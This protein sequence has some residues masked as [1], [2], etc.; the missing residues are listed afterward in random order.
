MSTDKRSVKDL[1]SNETVKQ[2]MS[3]SL[4][5]APEIDIYDQRQ[6]LNTSGTGTKRDFLRENQ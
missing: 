4:N 6:I 1:F 5:D 3:Q 2:S